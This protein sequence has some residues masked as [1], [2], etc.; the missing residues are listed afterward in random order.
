MDVSSVAASGLHQASSGLEKVM[1]KLSSTPNPVDAVSLSPE[2]AT[3]ST[4]H[5]AYSLDIKAM[6]VADQIASLAVYISG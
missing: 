5:I 4:Q 3:M 2:A 1:D 6:K